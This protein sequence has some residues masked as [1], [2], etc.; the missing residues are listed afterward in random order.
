M[1][2]CIL[3]M[4]MAMLTLFSSIELGMR[5]MEVNASQ[6]QTA[7]LSSP[8][9]SH[10]FSLPFKEFFDDGTWDDSPAHFLVTPSGS[11]IESAANGGFGGIGKSVVLSI[12]SGTTSSME[13]DTETT[14]AKGV[15]CFDFKFL[16]L[17]PVSIYAFDGT[18]QKWKVTIARHSGSDLFDV[19]LD[20]GSSTTS[21]DWI[22]PG[23]QR[24]NRWYTMQV[25]FDSDTPTA[26]CE[27][28]IDTEKV[29]TK[30]VTSGAFGCSKFKI[31][32]TKQSSEAA[33]QCII[34]DNVIT[35]PRS[36]RIKNPTSPVINLIFCDDYYTEN[37]PMGSQTAFINI[38]EIECPPYVNP[39][40][41]PYH[42]SS[43]SISNCIFLGYSSSTRRVVP[44]IAIRISNADK[45]FTGN[46]ISVSISN[47]YVKHVKWGVYIDDAGTSGSITVENSYMSGILE[48]APVPGGGIYATHLDSL[49][50]TGNTVISLVEQYATVVGDTNQQS[51]TA[52][53]YLSSVP[54][55]TIQ[56]NTFIQCGLNIETDGT[57]TDIGTYTISGNTVNGKLLYFAHDSSTLVLDGRTD[58]GQVVLL[59]CDEPKISNMEF[60]NMGI[61]MLHCT[62]TSVNQP[63]VYKVS[64]GNIAYNAIT[65][66][67]CHGI[68][69]DSCSFNKIGFIGIKTYYGYENVIRCCD[70]YE[71]GAR[72]MFISSL[73]H[74]GG[75]GHRTIVEYNRMNQVMGRAIEVSSG[76][77]VLIQ[78]NV[79]VS[80]KNGIVLSSTFGDS[81]MITTVRSNYIRRGTP[82]AISDVDGGDNI[83][84]GI[85]LGAGDDCRISRN[86]IL[87]FDY[88]IRCEGDPSTQILIDRN[89]V[90]DCTMDGLKISKTGDYLITNNDFWNNKGYGVNFADDLVNNVDEDFEQGYYIGDQDLVGAGPGRWTA[91]DS[92]TSPKCYLQGVDK[93]GKM[94]GQSGA[95]WAWDSAS[96][97]PPSSG[98]TW[99][100]ATVQ[101]ENIGGGSLSLSPIADNGASL[102][103]V[104]FVGSTYQ[105]MLNGVNL[106][107]TFTSTTYYVKM[108][109]NLGTGMDKCYVE[110]STDE[111]TW[112][113]YVNYGNYF[114]MTHLTPAKLSIFGSMN[115]AYILN[116][117]CEWTSDARITVLDNNF[118]MNHQGITPPY[119]GYGTRYAII[120]TGNY[121]D[122]GT[123]KVY[124]ACT[125]YCPST[126]LE[127]YPCVT[128]ARFDS[129]TDLVARVVLP[130]DFD[131]TRVQNDG[132]DLRCYTIDGVTPLYY[133]ILKWNVGGVSDF[134][135]F[136]PFPGTRGILIRSGNPGASQGSNYFMEPV[137]FDATV[138]SKIKTADEDFQAYGNGIE[139]QTEPSWSISGSQQTYP[140]I[141][142]MTNKDAWN[143]RLKIHDDSFSTK[144]GACYIFGSSRFPTLSTQ[145][146]VRF[147]LTIM[148]SGSYLYLNF[149]QGY[150]YDTSPKVSIRIDSS[151]KVYSN[152]G[153]AD[154]WKD[155]KIVI[156]T[157]GVLTPMMVVMLSPTT[158]AIASGISVSSKYKTAVMKNKATWT[159]SWTQMSIETDLSGTNE[160]FLDNI[161]CSCKIEKENFETYLFGSFQSQGS[162]FINPGSPVSTQFN[163]S[164]DDSNR[165]QVTQL[166]L[167]S[168]N[169][170]AR[171]AFATQSEVPSTQNF[172]VGIDLKVTAAPGNTWFYTILLKDASMNGKINII[173]D[174][175]CNN[176]RSYDGIV[177]YNWVTVQWYDSTNNP[178]T[179]PGLLGGEWRVTT[180]LTSASLHKIYLL[181]KD[182]DIEYHSGNLN[183]W[184]TW[185]TSGVKY[186]QTTTHRDGTAGTSQ[187]LIDNLAASWY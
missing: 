10:T 167:H 18:T 23:Y 46:S 88:G 82:Y 110:I 134:K 95:N 61:L 64:M 154:P 47:I 146:L 42:I 141:Y 58:I 36:G 90:H 139:I 55:T 106:G 79:I 104:Q 51:S 43:V 41:S 171:Y 148:P 168:S 173:Y 94:T 2:I 13:L 29:A 93:V 68:V 172:E 35:G 21:S 187:Y 117:N 136:I 40:D 26:H 162:W 20:G 7:Q 87:E 52:G 101:I 50:A 181:N 59:R 80:T 98:W 22:W 37:V 164:Q 33:G 24:I 114:A 152:D 170:D 17:Y 120:W 25:K 179:N 49:I 176:L 103:T 180:R 8:T 12:P 135:V 182:T 73:D 177:T 31:E 112:T 121:W 128:I 116:I 153:S 156:E 124:D 151:G 1:K 100:M 70:F 89:Y 126:P 86:E 38:T 45:K 183:N 62:G 96:G 144:I 132:D 109:F 85:N 113:S 57:E 163:I 137:D 75:A 131:Y 166:N 145:P 71:V 155:T 105:I 53:I 125:G 4:F 65:L 149:G 165:L 158:H 178:V 129:T 150:I 63:H 28:F 66:A 119:Q 97:S 39:P 140:T 161:D 147:D 99:I 60:S 133:W 81:C 48:N 6:E 115:V 34:V 77:N 130:P 143:N 157:T 15:F 76:Y 127:T 118:K 138:L 54:A 72:A 74:Q 16:G 56:S 9:A 123:Y 3:G 142:A 122:P 185:S 102:F 44:D 14:T 169:A 107:S 19:M 78:G 91:L 174:K 184:N 69:I 11:V 159:D 92:Y 27:V 67:D 30:S 32:A 175:A 111:A 186:Y 5:M 160:A 83:F 108:Y 84:T